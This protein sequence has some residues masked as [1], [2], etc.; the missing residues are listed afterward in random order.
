MAYAAGIIP[1][2][3]YRKINMSDN[4]ERSIDYG[5][6]FTPCTCSGGPDVHST[7]LGL[8]SGEVYVF[9]DHGRLYYSQNYAESFT[10]L[11]DLYLLTI[12]HLTGRF[13]MN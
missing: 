7:A 9:G 2:E 11:S 12:Q 8:D 13:A 6:H 1:G 3:I 4:I 10:F 5:D